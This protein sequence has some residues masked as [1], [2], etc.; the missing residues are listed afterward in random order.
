MATKKRKATRKKRAAPKRKTQ[1]VMVNPKRKPVRRRRSASP[2]RRKRSSRRRRNPTVKWSDAFMASL[3]GTAGG[4]V[5]YGLD[6]G[7]SYAPVGA[8][9]QAGIGFGVGALTS[10]LLN[11]WAS[12]EVGA[13]I[14]GA[15][16]YATIGRVRNAMALSALGNAAPDAGRVGR[17]RRS[18][19][20]NAEAG[21][22]GMAQVN[23]A[24]SLHMGSASLKAN[25]AGA[26]R[27]VTMPANTANYGPNNWTRYYQMGS[28]HRDEAGR[29]IRVRNVFNS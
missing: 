14:A 28:A 16:T 20:A 27:Y 17:V 1:I 7:V 29:V 11:K 10:V 19:I 13:G 4:V 3:K 9:A 24:Q 21:R 26:N 8:Y 18:R 25:D 6:F 23:P 5:G 15:T 12:P 2:V 22:V